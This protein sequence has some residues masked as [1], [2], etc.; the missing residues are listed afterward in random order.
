M[1]D[2]EPDE[3]STVL[4]ARFDPSAEAVTTLGLEV[5]EGPDR[6]RSF[7]VEVGPERVL[8]GQGPSCLMRLGDPSVSRRHASLE[9]REGQVLLTDLGSKNGTRV[10]SVPVVAA[11]LRGAGE[12]VTVGSTTLVVTARPAARVAPAP[13][14]TAFGAV[15]GASTEMRRLYPVFERLAATVVPVIREGETGTGKEA[16]A[17]AIHRQGSRATGPFVVFDCTA[18][19][20]SLLES[21]LFGHEKGAFT[22]A[23]AARKGVFE[24]AHGGT[25]L[26]DE[27]G[28]LRLDL[29]PKLLRAIERSEIK[30]VGGNQT[31][32]V[33]VRILAATRRDLD[34][35]VQEGRFRDDLLHRLSVV[36]VELPPLRQRRG[37]VGVLAAHF[38]THLGGD[39]RADLPPSLLARWA[40]EPWPGN[41]REL[42]NAVARH[43]AL[44]DLVHT[45]TALPAG[46]PGV[47]PTPA[48][49]DLV[50][51]VIAAQLPLSEARARVV[52]GF[53]RRYLEDALARSGGN[54]TRA[55]QAAGVAV[56]YLQML[57]AERR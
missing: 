7:T 10:D 31:L 11:W 17:E 45:L 37:D 47:S 16:L 53:V 55:A 30:R 23:V 8:L 43:L 9:R 57:R 52:D 26:I 1:I 39:P 25:L 28:D 6:G 35:E 38:C 54:V 4:Q 42:R 5:V 21:E 48:P 41:V 24:Q 32:R 36:R 27:I 14:R 15:V 40:R 3:H 34:R 2:D 22:G 19:P 20:D 51:E 13:A 56:R 12:R 33:D 29:Q 18:V 49:G 44:G 46:D 50:A